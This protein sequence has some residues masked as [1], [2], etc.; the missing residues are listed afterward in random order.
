MNARTVFE[1]GE[2]GQIHDRLDQA[3]ECCEPKPMEPEVAG[4]DD[5]GEEEPSDS[6]E[7]PDPAK[8]Q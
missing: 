7:E 8:M 1:C 3:E 2:C 6:D 4:I 5:L